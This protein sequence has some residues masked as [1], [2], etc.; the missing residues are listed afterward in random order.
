MNIGV[1]LP[2]YRRPVCVAKDC[3]GQ[4]V[5]GFDDYTDPEVIYILCDKCGHVVAVLGDR[6][7][8]IESSC[9]QITIPAA[10]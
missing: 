4:L 9:P 3:D 7:E 2:M 6:K 1:D 10:S 5:V 8:V